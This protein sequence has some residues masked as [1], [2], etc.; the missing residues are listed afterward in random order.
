MVL[1][2]EDEFARASLNGVGSPG[3]MT[4]LPTGERNQS[5]FG[6]TQL[7]VDA[8]YVA[9]TGV[10]PGIDPFSIVADPSDPADGVLTITAQ[11]TPSQYANDIPTPYVSGHINTANAF[12]Y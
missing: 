6:Q 8:D 12:E 9:K 3:Y 4:T 10:K 7:W 11:P 2:F 1:S 5:Q